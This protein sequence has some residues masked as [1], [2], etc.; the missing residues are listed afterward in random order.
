[1]ETGG[2]TEKSLLRE[3]TAGRDGDRD[4]P[5]KEEYGY[6]WPTSLP[7]TTLVTGGCTGR[8]GSLCL[9]QPKLNIFEPQTT[10]GKRCINP[11]SS[12]VMSETTRIINRSGTT[13][14]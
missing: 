14:S 1:M 9:V 10:P 6:F 4:L 5:K 11:R 2:E 3:K 7:W 12:A 13:F 8:P